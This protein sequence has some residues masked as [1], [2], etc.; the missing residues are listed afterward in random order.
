MDKAHI[1]MPR[2]T[3]ESGLI[4]NIKFSGLYGISFFAF[5][6]IGLAGSIYHVSTWWILKK[7]QLLDQMNNN[8]F[9]Y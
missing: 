8:I 5:L 2:T 6:V 4:L 7:N 3:F 1:W 9:V